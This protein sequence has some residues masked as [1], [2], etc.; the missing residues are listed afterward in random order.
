MTSINRSC[1]CGAQYKAELCESL[2]RIGETYNSSYAL[3]LPSN[4]YGNPGTYTTGHYFKDNQNL[5]YGPAFTN[6]MDATGADRTTPEVP[7]GGVG[8]TTNVSALK[9]VNDAK[10]NTVNFANCEDCLRYHI[11]HKNTLDGTA[12]DGSYGRLYAILAQCDCNDYFQFNQDNDGGDESAF[13]RFAWP[14]CKIEM[15]TDAT[16]PPDTY[17]TTHDDCPAGRTR[18]G[19]ELND[20]K[21][22]NEA[23]NTQQDG[24]PN[25]MAATY[26][27][28]DYTPLLEEVRDSSS[29]NPFYITPDADILGVP[30]D[31]PNHTAV[32]PGDGTSRSIPNATL[33]T[34]GKITFASDETDKNNVNHRFGGSGSRVPLNFFSG[35]NRSSNYFAFDNTN[36]NVVTANNQSI[37]LLAGGV[38]KTYT[39]ITTGTP[40]GT[41]FKAETSATQTAANFKA[42]VEGSNGHGLAKLMVETQN[43]EVYITQT[44]PGEAG[45]TAV[46][47]SGN[48]NNATSFNISSTFT[49][50]SDQSDNMT[51]EGDNK[52]TFVIMKVDPLVDTTYNQSRAVYRAFKVVGFSQY[53]PAVDSSYTS[54]AGA[55]K[56]LKLSH[57]DEIHFRMNPLGSSLYYGAESALAEANSSSCYGSNSSNPVKNTALLGT[58]KILGGLNTDAA[59]ASNKWQGGDPCTRAY[60]SNPSLNGTG[61]ALKIKDYG[62]FCK[63][64]QY[65]PE[66]V[67]IVR[68]FDITTKNSPWMN[69]AVSD[70]RRRNCLGNFDNVHVAWDDSDK[71]IKDGEFGTTLGLSGAPWG[72]DVLGGGPDESGVLRLEFTYT[73]NT[74]TTCNLVDAQPLDFPTV[75]PNRNYAFECPN[76]TNGR[77]DLGQTEPYTCHYKLASITSNQGDVIHWISDPSIYLRNPLL[78]EVTDSNAR[79]LLDRR[80][81]IDSNDTNCVVSG[82]QLGCNGDSTVERLFYNNNIIG[83][84]NNGNTLSRTNTARRQYNAL[85]SACIDPP[86]GE[87]NAYYANVCKNSNGSYYWYGGYDFGVA[88]PILTCA[89][90]L[91]LSNIGSTN[92]KRNG[93][94]NNSFFSGL[95][96]CELS[97]ELNDPNSVVL[98]GPLVEAWCPPTLTVEENRGQKDP[99]DPGR[100]LDARTAY[101]GLGIPSYAPTHPSESLSNAGEIDS[102]FNIYPS[103]G[104]YNY[105]D[106]E[107]SGGLGA[108][109]GGHTFM[110]TFTIG[111]RHVPLPDTKSN[112]AFLKSD[113]IGVDPP[114]GGAS[115][116]ELNGE[117]FER[118]RYELSTYVI[119]AGLYVFRIEDGDICTSDSGSLNTTS[120]TNRCVFGFSMPIPQSVHTTH[121]NNTSTRIP[122]KFLQWWEGFYRSYAQPGQKTFASSLTPFTKGLP[123]C[124]DNDNMTTSMF[125]AGSEWEYCGDMEGGNHQDTAIQTICD[126]VTNSTA[127][128]NSYWDSCCTIKS[129]GSC[130]GDGQPTCSCA[131]CQTDCVGGGFG[132][133]D[134]CQ[135]GGDGEE[136]P[137]TGIEPCDGCYGGGSDGSFSCPVDSFG[138]CTDEHIVLSNP[139]LDASNNNNIVE[140]VEGDIHEI[141]CREAAA[142]EVFKQSTQNAAIATSCLY[143]DDWSFYQECFEAAEYVCCCAGNAAI[144]G[145]CCG[146]EDDPVRDENN[147]TCGQCS[148]I[149]RL[150]QPGQSTCSSEQNCCYNRAGCSQN[151]EYWGPSKGKTGNSWAKTL[152]RW[153]IRSGVAPP[154]IRALTSAKEAWRHIPKNTS[155]QNVAISGS[156]NGSSASSRLLF[157]PPS[158]DSATNM[159]LNCDIRFIKP[160][161]KYLYSQ[162]QYDPLNH[163]DAPD[164]DGTTQECGFCQNQ[165]TDNIANEYTSRYFGKKTP[166]STFA[167]QTHNWSTTHGLI[168]V[169]SLIDM[170]CS[171]RDYVSKYSSNLV[172]HG[173]FT[174]LDYKTYRDNT[175]LT[176]A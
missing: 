2:S 135:Y 41:Q 108:N 5:C 148:T 110:P 121:F 34:G 8:Y 38:S 39:L 155:G 119:P 44:V 140:I 103:T 138:R 46:T 156:N 81:L 133:D 125:H 105:D 32:N 123:S 6:Q 9:F 128:C 47:N 37:T 49:G 111:I 17:Q 116:D 147:F 66:T 175:S 92:F 91:C 82:T 69:A 50:G 100:R 31:N 58:A 78:G 33:V 90:P 139:D 43:N 107:I 134:S 24:V 79:T 95:S 1:C 13:E 165:V 164:N 72:S 141:T 172:W 101:V 23:S 173:S 61:A 144:G 52:G 80:Y 146:I 104:I 57:V 161:N 28:L 158:H 84:D 163:Y 96:F 131:A 117:N 162:I 168:H 19:E 152:D 109:A 89:N 122:P 106:N 88:C 27:Y 167:S 73:R 112:Q 127:N 124:L 142:I 45:N 4:L 151:G 29:T 115:R 145:Y 76:L 157:Y 97:G 118:F 20:Y 86:D 136:P 53:K 21:I 11:T 60:L 22:Y 126:C 114:A 67:T 64:S 130:G 68:E 166:V 159:N 30:Y 150:N 18:S 62:D 75:D 70:K 120:A 36:Y 94:F 65:L 102:R 174:Q 154:S 93:N 56:E 15:S 153:E 176:I 26:F 71:H 25:D 169:S 143:E 16:S 14:T 63:N 129:G 51:T 48:F 149:G 87:E 137:I 3:W 98:S 54:S 171:D 83:K 170:G 7:L 55:I 59:T 99:V 74:K 35:S 113:E 85:S 10:A 160:P 132:Q 42:V 77:I 40:S 12:G